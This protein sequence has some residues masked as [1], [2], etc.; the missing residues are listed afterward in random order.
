MGEINIKSTLQDTGPIILNGR[1]MQFNGIDEPVTSAERTD[2]DSQEDLILSKY[3]FMQELTNTTRLP[4]R[5]QNGDSRN[6]AEELN[7]IK[8]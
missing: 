1:L 8:P 4:L 3:H 2:W 6:W 5:K 7:S